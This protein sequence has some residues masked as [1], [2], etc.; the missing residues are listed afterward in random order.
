[1]ITAS[2]A[3]A[4]K[5]KKPAVIKEN[6]APRFVVLDWETFNAWQEMR[7]DFEDTARLV[8]A[9]ADPKTKNAFLLQLLKS[10]L[11]FHDPRF[12]PSKGN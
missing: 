12:A 4:I 2:L 8:E 3:R 1:M 9:L 7:E 5:G 10:G 11:I 6:G